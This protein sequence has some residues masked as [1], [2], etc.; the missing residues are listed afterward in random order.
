MGLDLTTAQAQFIR[1]LILEEGPQHLTGMPLDRAA[2]CM[3]GLAKLD[4]ALA[5]SEP[6]V[7]IVETEP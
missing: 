2:H 3:E 1:K 6:K 5:W 7:G 4:E